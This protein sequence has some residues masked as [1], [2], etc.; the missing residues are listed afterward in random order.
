MNNIA[1]QKDLI[2]IGAGP[3]GLA[4]A[5]EAKKNGIDDI[6]VIERDEFAG[7]ILRQ[8]IHDGFGLQIFGERL[9]GPEYALRFIDEANELG[10]EILLNTF[11]LDISNDK[12]VTVINKDTGIQVY[13]ASSVI[14][15]MGCRERNRGAILIP[16]DRPAGIYTAGLVQRLVNIDGYLPGKKAV[17]LGSG[18]IGLI[19]ARRLTLEGAQVL[20]VYELMS[21]SSGLKRNIVQCL[22]DFNI[23][24]YF[25]HTVTQVHGKERLE[26]I[27][28]AEVD[29]NRRPIPA[30]ER[31]IEC[32]LL[33]LSVG[34]IPENELSRNANVTLNNKTG[35]IIVDDTLS[36][37]VDGIF[38]CGNVVHV[39]DLVDFVTYE[40]RKAG[41]FAALYLKNNNSNIADNKDIYNISAQNGVRYVVPNKI[42]KNNSGI[43]NVDM[44]FRV[45][46]VYNN[47]SVVIE[48]NGKTIKKVP[49]KTVTPGEMEKVILTSRDISQLDSDEVIIR[50]EK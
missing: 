43:G 47:V 7:G 30:T 33:V 31:Y 27:S 10:I 24:L 49:K 4:A 11:V 12:K 1:L 29:S 34:L 26:G 41:K 37:S 45:D 32:D 9:T 14:L 36:T 38:A 22:E 21:Y 42:H 46:N 6:L 39:H 35:G 2:V 17:I 3:A 20:G 40:S 48:C 13:S 28:V 44:L 8:C 50:L 15:S 19:M 5:I 23:P 16:G 25:N 18:D